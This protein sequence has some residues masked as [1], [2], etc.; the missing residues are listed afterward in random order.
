VTTSDVQ[1]RKAEFARY[2]A[3]NQARLYGYIHS[4][5][6]DLNHAD[7]LYQQTAL[8][9][10]GKFGEFDRA[11]SFFAWA[12]GVARFEAANFVRALARQRR[13]FGE[14]LGLLLI[15]A[16]EEM[17]ED[18]LADRKA[19][20]SKCVEQL[21]PA[22]RALLTECYLDPAG[23][24]A[25]AARRNRSVHSVYNSLRRIRQALLQCVQRTISRQT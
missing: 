22:D 1:D 20:L 23:V 10:W 12:C 5:V 17:A 25:A 4:L 15:E 13:F 18:E 14:E 11:R 9:L 6:P 3:E 2:L 16:H 21:R 24:P 8:V 7:D 19:A